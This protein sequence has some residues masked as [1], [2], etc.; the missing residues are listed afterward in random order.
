VHTSSKGPIYKEIIKNAE[1][2]ALFIP[3]WNT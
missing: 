2:V 3:D 1:A